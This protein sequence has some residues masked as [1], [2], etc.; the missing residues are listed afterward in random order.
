MVRFVQMIDALEATLDNLEDCIV[1]LQTS[2]M[3]TVVT[4]L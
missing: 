1:P 3:L 2:S 4:L